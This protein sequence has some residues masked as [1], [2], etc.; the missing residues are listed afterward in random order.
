M[1][2]SGC[3]A[4]VI[5]I[6]QVLDLPRQVRKTSVAACAAPCRALRR[7]LAGSPKFPEVIVFMR[8]SLPVTDSASILTDIITINKVSTSFGSGREMSIT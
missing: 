4:K 6:C 1:K 7:T 8:K 5:K 3:T 2:P